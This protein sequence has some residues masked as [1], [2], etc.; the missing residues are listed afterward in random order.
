MPCGAPQCWAV[1]SPTAAP[2]RARRRR[3]RPRRGPLAGAATGPAD[4]RRERGVGRRRA[5][6]D[7]TRVGGVE[8]RRRAHPGAPPRRRRARV[9]AEPQRRHRAPARGGRGRARFA[10]RTFVLDGEAISLADGALPHRFQDTMSRFGRDD[11]ASHARHSPRS[12][13]TLARRRR[14]LL[15]HPL[16]ERERDRP[17]HGGPE[18]RVPAVETTSMGPLKV[19]PRRRTR[20]PGTR[21]EVER[22]TPSTTPACPVPSRRKVEGAHARHV[23]PR[24]NGATAGAVAGVEPFTS[25]ARARHRRARH[26]RQDLLAVSTDERP[27]G[28]RRVRR[29]VAPGRS[30]GRSSRSRRRDRARRR[31][32]GDEYPCM[33]R[34][35][36]RARARVSTRQVCRR[37]R[38]DRRRTRAAGALSELRH[39]LVEVEVV[40]PLGDLPAAQL[41]RAHHG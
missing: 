34:V 28:G 31:A 27:P 13:S 20:R 6:G 14:D 1:T 10:A 39:V 41:E 4:A 23:V 32:D 29:R 2:P 25:R 24:R 26:G 8:A 38:H 5:R 11:A 16:A 35:A 36:I 7:R 15:D 33:A 12:S 21:A 9:H 3:R 37:R 19:V 40:A 30:R 22:S 17:D 18:A